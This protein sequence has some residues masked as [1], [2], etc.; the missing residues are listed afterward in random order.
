MKRCKDREAELAAKQEVIRVNVVRFE[1]F[2]KDNDTKR[3]RALKKERDEI[4][5]QLKLQ[6]EV[7]ALEL[8]ERQTRMSLMEL[9]DTLT[10]LAKYEE[11]LEEVVEASEFSEIPEV[12]FKFG[13]MRGTNED[14]RRFIETGNGGGGLPG[15]Q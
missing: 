11:F 4:A 1:R 6:Q 12:L 3:Q 14:L 10:R 9:M 7:E 13:T 8:L 2:I 5:E 15:E